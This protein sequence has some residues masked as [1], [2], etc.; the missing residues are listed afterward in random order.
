MESNQLKQISEI[1]KEKAV[2]D[3]KLQNSELKKEEMR[4]KME[5]EIN[6]LKE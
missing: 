5:N 2:L 6:V 1:Q 3:E 4:V